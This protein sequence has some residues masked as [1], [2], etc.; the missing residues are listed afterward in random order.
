MYVTVAICPQIVIKVFIAESYPSTKQDTSVLSTHTRVIDHPSTSSP[1]VGYMSNMASGAFP[2]VPQSFGLAGALAPPAHG[3]TTPGGR[4]A[5][6]LGA[7]PPARRPR[8]RDTAQVPP[9]APA[10]TNA[11]LTTI[12]Q[13]LITQMAS[14]HACFSSITDDMNDHA[15]RL[16]RLTLVTTTNTVEIQAS[17]V[18]SERVQT[19]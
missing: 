5:P 4:P 6:T 16:D 9:V 18:E 14:D 19:D 2:N 1:S 10:M 7:S 12:T 13:Q 8:V 15:A 11:E 3:A 17:K